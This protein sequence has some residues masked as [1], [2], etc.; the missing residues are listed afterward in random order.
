MDL[1]G[2]V[3]EGGC[4]SLCNQSQISIHPRDQADPHVTCY[5]NDCEK[6]GS[7]SLSI[8]AARS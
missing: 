6:F 8:H 4:C 2:A 5:P 1:I 3:A 7:V